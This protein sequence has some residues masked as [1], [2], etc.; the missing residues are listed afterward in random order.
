MTQGNVAQLVGHHAGHLAFGA[1]RLNHP[2]VHVHRSAG[3]SK[4]IYIACID[5]LEV[6]MKFRMLELGRDGRDQPLA[7]A[8]DVRAH[9]RIAQ[10]RKLLFRFGRCLAAQSH[11]IF[12]L[13][14]VGVIS[15][16]GLRE[17]RKRHQDNR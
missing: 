9:F 14:L 12:R 6:I 1:R 3:Q 15:D 10:Q 8:F 17:R 5:D 13:K 2:T 4:S 7:H 16:F 11:V